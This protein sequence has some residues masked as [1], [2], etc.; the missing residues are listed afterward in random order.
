VSQVNVNQ[1]TPSDDGGSSA[2]GAAINNVNTPA[3]QQPA[4]A[5][6]SKP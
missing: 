3:Q 5:A 2:G 1:P 4:P 6:P